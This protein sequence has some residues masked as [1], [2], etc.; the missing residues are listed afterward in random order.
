LRRMMSIKPD[1]FD[2]HINFPGGIPIDGPS[3]GLA[4]AVAIYS[5]LTN[6]SVDNKVAITG[7]VSI[8]GM[9][10]AV[11]GIT[12][13]I[14]AARRAGAKKVIIPEENWQNIY[15]KY[16]DIEI[17]TVKTLKEALQRTMKIKE[18]EKIKLISTERL[19]MA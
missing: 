8:R 1:D 18:E 7:E 2:I 19:I 13:K 11:G 3:A 12:S 5:A 6:N 10:K 17:V 16:N 9:V 14:E 4:I 15:E